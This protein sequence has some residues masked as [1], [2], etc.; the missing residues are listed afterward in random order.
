MNNGKIRVGI[1]HGDTNGIGYELIFKTFADAEML[2]LCT[3]IVYGSPKVATYHRNALGIEANFSIINSADQAEDNRVNMLAVFEDEVKVEFGVA[4][5][6]ASRAAVKALDKAIT[7]YKNGDIDVIVSCPVNENN[8]TVE[9]YAIP[10]PAK[11]IET[12]I[13]EGKKVLDIVMNE[14]L[15]VA[16]VTDDMALRD[17]PTNISAQAIIEKIAIFYATLRR[18]MRISAPR[19]AV[20]ALNPNDTEE[21]RGKEEQEMI[22]PAIQKLAEVNVCAFGPYQAADFFGSGQYKAFDGV[23]A[24]YHDQGIAPFKALLPNNNIH[25]YGGLPLI[26]T[27]VDMGPCYAIAGK[28]EADET[29]LRYAIYQAIDAFRNRN[30]YDEPLAHPLPKLYHERRDDSDKVRFA[31]SKKRENAAKEYQKQK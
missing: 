7:D 28:G 26:S 22:I 23:L 16:L 11:Y 3:P 12:S 21:R 17:V 14:W 24:M 13:G 20:L 10:K 8:L 31:V 2:G 25:Y 15:K 4:S 5:E 18:D 9:G 29:P 30:N 1:T 6:E 27:A 19:I